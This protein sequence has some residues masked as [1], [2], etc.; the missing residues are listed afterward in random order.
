LAAGGIGAGEGSVAGAA[1]AAAGFGFASARG[2]FDDEWAAAE[3]EVDVAPIDVSG[4][5][6]CARPAG[7]TQT[8][9]PRAT[10]SAVG[11]DV[12]TEWGPFDWL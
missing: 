5:G 11:T 6:I 1:L 7:G 4:A 2:F 3:V 10:R 8:M 12:F 9:T